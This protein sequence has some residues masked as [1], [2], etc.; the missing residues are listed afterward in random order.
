MLAH[1]KGKGRRGRL[2]SMILVAV[3]LCNNMPITGL[4]QGKEKVKSRWVVT[5]FQELPEEIYN[6]KVARGTGAEEM[7]ASLP[8]TLE[9]LAV[10][11]D[12]EEDVPETSQ[13]EIPTE[14]SS[15]ENESTEAASGEV[16]EAAEA[17]SEALT[18]G[19]K[20]E[21]STA[22]T[23]DADTSSGAGNPSPS[24]ETDEVSGPTAAPDVPENPTSD[25]PEADTS[26]PGILGGG[27]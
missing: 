19:T 6:R 11:E 13:A 21:D 22:E 14:E 9:A 26:L 4:A 7:K 23:P 10:K 3:M 8:D 12:M 2:I 1:E 24:T 5:D 27:G 16:N 18:E 20:E 25:A 17:T 15:K